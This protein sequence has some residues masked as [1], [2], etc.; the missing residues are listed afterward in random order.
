MTILSTTNIENTKNATRL[1]SQKTE[2]LTTAK[3]VVISG[4]IIESDRLKL[5]L[6]VRTETI[7][8]WKLIAYASTQL[9]KK[10][11]V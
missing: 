2:I 3:I 1:P 6:K 11:I 5:K 9:K 7:N 8:D 10:I 4:I